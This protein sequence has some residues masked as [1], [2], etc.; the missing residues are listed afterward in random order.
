MVASLAHVNGNGLFASFLHFFVAPDGSLLTNSFG[1]GNWT[2]L[3][4]LVIVV[5]LLGH[6]QR[7]RFAETQSQTLEVA[8][9]PEL[10]AV[11]AGGASRI[12]LRRI[13]ADD[14]PFTLLLGLS[15]IMVLVAQTVGIWDWRRRRFLEAVKRA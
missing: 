6:F 10:R 8:S 12:L 5:G 15:V 14:I 1:L 2:G 4:A 7:R 13:A 9:A 3:V 11:R